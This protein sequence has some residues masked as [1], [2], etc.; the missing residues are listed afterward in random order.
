MI[1]A[2]QVGVVGHI[3]IGDNVQVGAQSGVGQSLPADQAFSG[4][5]VMPH[6]EW[7][8]AV[9]IFQKLPEMKKTLIRIEK[10]LK[11]LEEALSLKE[12]E[13]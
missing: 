3:E 6:R 13:K 12:K 11:E 2:G 7:L 4:S 10:R 1:L 9:N 8:R 5:P